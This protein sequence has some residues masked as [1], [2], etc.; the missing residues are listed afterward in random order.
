[1]YDA[2]TFNYDVPY[3]KFTGTEQ[4]ARGVPVAGWLQ[5]HFMPLDG[6]QSGRVEALGSQPV[7]RFV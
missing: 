4:P 3:Y 2:P 1:M 7:C 5:N 6:L